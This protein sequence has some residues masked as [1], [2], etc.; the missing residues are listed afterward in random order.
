VG[1]G[2]ESGQSFN[3]FDRQTGKWHQIWVDSSGGVLRF[4]GEF[5][6][7]AM[8]FTSMVTGP[9]GPRIAHRLT[10][11]PN[12]DG[13]VRQLWESTPDGGTTWSVAFDGLYRKK[14]G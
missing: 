6:D 13:S 10:F 2:G 5:A 7:G 12:P 8:R 1:T 14:P 11:T 9:D 3:F 4:T